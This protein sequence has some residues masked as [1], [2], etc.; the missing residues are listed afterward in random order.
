MNVSSG[1]LVKTISD[2]FSD[3]IGVINELG[4][5]PRKAIGVLGFPPNGVV[6]GCLV[7]VSPLPTGRFEKGNNNDL[8]GSATEML[9]HVY[10]Y[11]APEI[12]CQRLVPRIASLAPISAAVYYNHDSSGSV[13]TVPYFAISLVGPWDLTEQQVII[14]CLG[15]V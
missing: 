10:Q 14:D 11:A 4:K 8:K 5:Q 12:Q 7:M 15:G 6:E 2:N 13:Q 3:Y 1:F 9:I